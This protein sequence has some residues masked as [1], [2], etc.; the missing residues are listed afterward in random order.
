MKRIGWT[1]SALA[2]VVMAVATLMPGSAAQAGYPEKTVTLVINWPAGGGSDRVF[3]LFAEHAK[4]QFGV[5]VIVVN[6]SGAGGANGTRAAASAKP[7]GYTVG[8]I[9]AGFIARQYSNPNANVLADIIPIAFL[10]PDPG[11]LQ[12]RPDTGIKSVK[13]YVA[14]AKANPGK[15]KNGNDQ[16]GGSSWMTA[17]LVEKGLKTKLTL[18]PYKGYAPTT[19]AL[20][21]G[22][23]N[24]A[25]LPVPEVIDHHKSGKVTLLAVAAEKRHFMAPDVPTFKEAGFD[26]IA[27][28][29]RVFFVPK[30]TPAGVQ[31]VLEQKLLATLN[32]P[33]FVKRANKAGFAITPMGAKATL[34][35]MKADDASLYP[36]LKGAGMVKVRMKK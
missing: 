16:P 25:T 21:S 34:A 22:E 17:K 4:K 8:T 31:K 5:A 24:S 1:S 2:A 14:Y 10:G 7:D 28:S 30:G 19:A 9:S 32:D 36:V 13:Q 12:V 11:A 15:L 33:L 35:R 27:G 20:L 26:V 29:W 23:I 18:V 3:R 6:K